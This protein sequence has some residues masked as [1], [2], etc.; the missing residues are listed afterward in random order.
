MTNTTE[1][2]YFRGMD[3]SETLQGAGGVGG[4]LAAS[5]NGQF[6]FPAYDNNGNITKYIDEGGN[7]VAAYEYDDFGRLLSSSGP[8]AEVFR[9]RFSTKY[10]DDETGLYYYGERFYTPT[11]MRWLTRDP[12]EEEGGL[13]LYCFC[14]G[15]PICFYDNLGLV[16]KNRSNA[17]K[18]QSVQLPWQNEFHT[19]NCVE[20]GSKGTK[21][22][23]VKHFNCYTF[24]D[25]P[26][27]RRSYFSYSLVDR[28]GM[29]FDTKACWCLNLVP[30]MLEKK[31][32]GKR[33]IFRFRAFVRLLD[34]HPCCGSKEI[35]M[36]NM[37]GKWITITY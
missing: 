29:N 13:N 12:S 33:E 11:L 37:E 14:N 2:Q 24:K 22:E 20:F 4:L 18:W 17:E 27:S 30:I 25:L 23:Y 35:H 8:M 16:P 1:V 7:V 21:D 15:N 36:R 32:E 31:V 9:H 28:L 19:Y 3:L 6:Y 26:A 10:Y 34:K 5:I